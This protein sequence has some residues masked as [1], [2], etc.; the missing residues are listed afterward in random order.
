MK[1]RYKTGAEKTPEHL[2]DGVPG[3]TEWRTRQTRGGAKEGEG[4]GAEGAN[5][6]CSQGTREVVG[7]YVAHPFSLHLCYTGDEVQR[8]EQ[9]KTESNPRGDVKTLTLFPHVVALAFLCYFRGTKGRRR[10]FLIWVYL[11][12]FPPPMSRSSARFPLPFSLCSFF[13]CF[14]LLF[15]FFLFLFLLYFTLSFL[16]LSTFTALPLYLSSLSVP[17]FASIPFLLSI[18]YLPVSCIPSLLSVSVPSHLSPPSLS[19]V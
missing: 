4:Q 11:R 9:L 10:S 1:V 6:G 14:S 2:K 12:L 8:G 13:V 5:N 15:S 16:C 7:R 19:S 18:F 3:R 17:S